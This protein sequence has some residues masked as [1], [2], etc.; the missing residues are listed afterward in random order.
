MN[1]CL[2]SMPGGYPLQDIV[3]ASK[4]HL[5]VQTD[6]V[7]LYLPAADA[8]LNLE[9][10]NRTRTAFK[11]LAEVQVLDLAQPISFVDLEDTIKRTTVVYLPGGN[12]YLLLD[13]LCRS[14]AFHL[15]KSQVQAGMPYVGFSAGT[16]ICGENILTTNDDNDCG[17]TQFTGLGF[18]QYNFVAHFPASTGK[19]REFRD[20]R[21]REYHKT[22]TNPVLAIED[23]GCITVD[24]KGTKVVRRHCWLFEAGREKKLLKPGYIS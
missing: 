21:I 20:N 3:A 18:T 17:C 5:E 19:E 15:I 14:G 13:R 24:H 7:V 2:F 6:P 23:D 10:V 16:I 8:T 22:Y 1:L 4:P 11:I 12:T 9:Y